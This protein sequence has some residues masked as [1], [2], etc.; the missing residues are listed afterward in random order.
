MPITFIHSEITLSLQECT[1]VGCVLTTAVFVQG[2]LPPGGCCLPPPVNR[3]T[4]LK[5]LS[6]LAVMNRFYCPP[7]A[8]WL[9]IKEKLIVLSIEIFNHSQNIMQEIEKLLSICELVGNC[10]CFM[11]IVNQAKYYE[12]FTRR[13]TYNKSNESY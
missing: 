13:G 9:K 6:S 3:Q 8:D 5:I 12:Y 10:R 2:G 11:I 1:P 4:G 7:F